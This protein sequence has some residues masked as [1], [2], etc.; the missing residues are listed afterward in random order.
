MTSKSIED[1]MREMENKP[2]C[3]KYSCNQ[4]G[5][6]HRCY[7]YMFNFC[8]FYTNKAVIMDEGDATEELIKRI[9]KNY[10]EH[11]PEDLP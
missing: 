1:K 6:H 2:E 8:N 11:P 5:K 3:P 9:K 10:Q 4:F 7:D